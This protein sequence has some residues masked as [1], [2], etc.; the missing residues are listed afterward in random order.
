MIQHLRNTVR[1]GINK[2]TI[3]TAVSESLKQDTIDLIDP[4]KE[5]RVIYNFIDEKTYVPSRCW[6][7][8]SR[9]WYS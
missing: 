3:V 7:I 4:N 5:I 8:E 9:S 6:N 2:S 1:Y